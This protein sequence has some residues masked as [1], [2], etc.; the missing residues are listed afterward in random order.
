VILRVLAGK[1]KLRPGVLFKL[2]EFLK[3]KRELS[4]L[5]LASLLDL[6]SHLLEDS[7]LMKSVT[8]HLHGHRGPLH[9]VLIRLGVEIS[10]GVRMELPD[11]NTIPFAR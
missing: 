3:Q 5:W 1:R 11:K 7:W 4:E 2:F 8:V 10:L 9:L 6:C